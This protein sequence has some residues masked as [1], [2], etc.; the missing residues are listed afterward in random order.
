MSEQNIQ[1]LI[2]QIVE[3]HYDLI[4]TANVKNATN[5]E[6]FEQWATTMAKAHGG[7]TLRFMFAEDEFEKAYNESIQDEPTEPAAN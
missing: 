6:E 2:Q 4:W 7:V 5:I 3:T 1:T